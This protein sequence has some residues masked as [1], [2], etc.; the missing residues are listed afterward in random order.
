MHRAQRGANVLQNGA[1]IPVALR[2]ALEARAAL[3]Q[4]TPILL[5]NAEV[6]TVLLFVVA[7]GVVG[8]HVLS[9]KHGDSKVERI[10][11]R[12]GDLLLARSESSDGVGATV[13]TGLKLGGWESQCCAAERQG[14]E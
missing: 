1:I 7:V 6:G 10:G 9:L 14:D 11:A 2:L 4:Q 12:C 8:C 5:E 3:A 13:L